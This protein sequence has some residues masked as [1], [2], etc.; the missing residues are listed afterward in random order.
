[1][2]KKMEKALKKKANEK[3][4]KGDRAGAYVY[5]T[6]EKMS[7]KKGNRKKKKYMKKDKMDFTME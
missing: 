6:M 4:L 3:G 5:G 1:M 2:P 7:K